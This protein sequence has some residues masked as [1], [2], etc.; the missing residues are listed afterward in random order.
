M[1]EVS[2]ED[3]KQVEISVPEQVDENSSGTKVPK[4]TQSINNSHDSNKQK[5]KSGGSYQYSKSIAASMKS[6][7][8][9]SKSKEKP[10][11]SLLD[12]TSKCLQAVYNDEISSLELELNNCKERDMKMLKFELLMSFFLAAHT[13]KKAI[14]EVI[15]HYNNFISETVSGVVREYNEMEDYHEDQDE[16]H[17]Q[18]GRNNDDKSIIS[19]DAMRTGNKVNT[20]RLFEFGNKKITNIRTILKSPAGE[21]YCTNCITVCLLSQEEKLASSLLV[22]Y[23]IKVQENMLHRAIAGQMF[24]FLFFMWIYDKNFSEENGRD[25]EFKFEELF[26]HILKICDDKAITRIKEVADWNVHPQGENILKA[27]LKNN[28]DSVA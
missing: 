25:K 2:K 19:A 3:E 23:P 1:E 16:S 18:I 15:Y 28:I 26:E 13:G 17:S 22:E 4:I 5:D 6:S 27:L 10:R 24:K 7:A 21:K 12:L 20:N 14:C 9:S 8:G 11:I